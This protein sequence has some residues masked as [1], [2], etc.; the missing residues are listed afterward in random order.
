MEQIQFGSLCKLF[1]VLKRVR[2]VSNHNYAYI[3]DSAKLLTAV[4][5]IRESLCIKPGVVGDVFIAGKP[6]KAYLCKLLYRVGD[7]NET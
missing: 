2:R 3:L 7:L 5:F 6:S 1:Q 4:P